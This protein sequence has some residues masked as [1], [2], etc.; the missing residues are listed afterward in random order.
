[1]NSQRKKSNIFLTGPSRSGTTLVCV[2]LNKIPDMVAIHEPFGI[3]AFGKESWRNKKSFCLDIERFIENSRESLLS[4]G[5]V[6]S[7]QFEGEIT[8]N[9]AANEYP[10]KSAVV[11]SK[12][13]SAITPR[14]KDR[15]NSQLNLRRI[16]HSQN[17][18]KIEKALSNDFK[19]VVKHNLIFTSLLEQ[20]V[21]NNLCYAIIRNPLSTLASWNT[22]NF[23]LEQGNLPIW[24]NT[25][26]KETYDLIIA[27]DDILE[28]QVR[29]LEWFLFQYKKYLQPEN[30]IT[31]ESIIDTGGASLAVI[32]EQAS[33]LNEKFVSNN[34]NPLYPDKLLKNIA[35]RILKRESIIWFFHKKED[36]EFLLETRNI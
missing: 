21:P 31:Y 8:S 16:V 26:E 7:R 34:N 29:L 14:W 9:P 15:A 17:T 20:L 1:M 2:L 18:I 3:T 27:S 24:F 13:R 4:N 30:I 25:W 19:L 28:R 23:G 10:T 6:V 12:I 36:V 35:H 22:I 11:L 33:T 5:E 32:N